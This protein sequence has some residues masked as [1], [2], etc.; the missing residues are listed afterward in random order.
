MTKLHTGE[1]CPRCRDG[2]IFRVPRRRW[3]RLLPSSKHYLCNDCLTR[4]L[5]V[6]AMAI[7]LPKAKGN[8]EAFN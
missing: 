3:M 5:T 1:R 4:F 6:C 8:P 7:R 2:E